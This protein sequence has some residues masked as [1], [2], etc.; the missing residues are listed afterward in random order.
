MHRIGLTGGIGS[1]KSYVSAL[2]RNRG[3]PVYDS[4]SEAKNIL[5]NDPVVISEISAL[6]GVKVVKKGIVDKSALASILFV[7]NDVALKVERIV[8]PRVR[9][10]F[11]DW[12]R[13]QKTKICVIES[14]ILF[15]SGF[16]SEVD[17]VV[18]VDAPESLCLSRTLARDH[19]TTAMFFAR[20]SLQM[21]QKRKMEKATFVIINDGVAAL[22]PQID[23]LLTNLEYFLENNLQ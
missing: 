15:E 16:N 23:N 3:I 17:F 10:S 14:A 21:D 2:L 20:S 18:V 13:K 11:Q 6:L 5:D 7:N 4:D 8:H 12:C 9:K 19:M 22:E 1:G